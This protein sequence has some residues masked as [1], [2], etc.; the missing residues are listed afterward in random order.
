MSEPDLR[1]DQCG[2][3]RQEPVSQALLGGRVGHGKC[4]QQFFSVLFSLKNSNILVLL[5]KKFMHMGFEY[6]AVV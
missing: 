5:A 1:N 2:V 4:R 3:G 6:Q